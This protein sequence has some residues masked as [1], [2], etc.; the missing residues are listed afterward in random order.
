ARGNALGINLSDTFAGGRE[1]LQ[2]KKGSDSNLVFGSVAG[3]AV[4]ES[5]RISN[6]AT[7]TSVTTT[8]PSRSFDGDSR[9]KETHSPH[10]ME[11]GAAT[12]FE[13]VGVYGD[14]GRPRLPLMTHQSGLLLGGF[15][16]V[17]NSVWRAVERLGAPLSLTR[18]VV[19]RTAVGNQ[20]P[21]IAKAPGIGQSTELISARWSHGMSA[22]ESSTIFPRS[23][24]A[25][26][27]VMSMRSGTMTAPAVLRR[28][29]AF[30]NQGQYAASP[31]IRGTAHDMPF[32]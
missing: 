11:A 16:A 26:P 10:T 7:E 19:S 5:G 25:V 17:K 2:T 27:I 4:M 20:L 13:T 3:R 21:W 30:A 14:I 12:G 6:D 28:S 18:T 9:P 24:A 1:T 31:A 32:V 8:S 29:H 15:P 23:E 22:E